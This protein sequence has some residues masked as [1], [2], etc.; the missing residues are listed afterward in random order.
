MEKVFHG[1]AK[2]EEKK[3]GAEVALEEGSSPRRGGGGWRVVPA[4]Q[5]PRVPMS[6]RVQSRPRASGLSGEGVVAGV[7]W[8]GELQSLLLR[9][10]DGGCW[11]GPES[12]PGFMG[13]SLRGL[14]EVPSLG[15]AP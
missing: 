8:A 2:S 1:L 12:T 5:Y 9:E 3:K 4:G 13:A 10:P 6:L 7:P 15:W 11:M 14:G